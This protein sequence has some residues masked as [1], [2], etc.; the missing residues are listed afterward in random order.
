MSLLLR[1][2]CCM[3]GSVVL[4]VTRPPL[5]S[6]ETSGKYRRTEIFSAPQRQ[7]EDDTVICYGYMA[8]VLQVVLNVRPSDYESEVLIN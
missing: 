7:P 5:H 2:W 4:S 1:V 6:L 3:R 8:S